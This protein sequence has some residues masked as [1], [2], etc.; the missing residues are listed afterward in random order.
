MKKTTM[1]ALGLLSSVFAG[2]A[3][4]AEPA[5]LPGLASEYLMTCAEASA[6]AKTDAAYVADVVASM[7]NASV[8]ARSL[9]I[10]PAKDLD[11]RVVKVMGDVCKKDPDGLLINA[12]DSA[13]RSVASK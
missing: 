12:V 8:E 7:G 9:K 13:M 10:K 4:A 2:A 5:K 6:E 3:V 1:I 11:A